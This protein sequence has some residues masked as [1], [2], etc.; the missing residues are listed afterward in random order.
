MKRLLETVRES[1]DSDRLRQ[2]QEQMEGERRVKE[3]Q[4]ARKREEEEKLAQERIV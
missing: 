4:E 3:Q 2:L 1:Q